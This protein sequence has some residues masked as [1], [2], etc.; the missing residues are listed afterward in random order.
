MKEREMGVFTGNFVLVF[1]IVW[2]MGDENFENS[3]LCKPLDFEIPDN[4][5]W[6][7]FHV[8]E[9]RVSSLLLRF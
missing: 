3:R 1:A 9:D 4:C 6:L 5:R 2:H 7:D 8:T